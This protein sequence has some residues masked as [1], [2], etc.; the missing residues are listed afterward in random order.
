MQIDY[1]GPDLPFCFRWPRTAKKRTSN[2]LFEL[3]PEQF[4]ATKNVF[5]MACL[6][7]SMVPIHH[8]RHAQDKLPERLESRHVHPTTLN[9]RHFECWRPCVDHVLRAFYCSNANKARV[10]AVAAPQLPSQIAL[11]KCSAWIG[12][13]CQL[14]GILSTS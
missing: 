11:L 1:C 4:L 3:G 6:P 14:V 8:A 13:V 10:S 2:S 7:F 5:F 9:Q 12:E